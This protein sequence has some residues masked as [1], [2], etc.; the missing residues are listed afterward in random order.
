MRIATFNLENLDDDEGAAPPLAARVA[1]LRPILERL[2]VDVLCLQEVN[3]QKPDKHATR[4]L[5]AL[6]ALLAGTRYAGFERAFTTGPDGVGPQDVHNL[7]TLSRFPLRERRQIRHD[8]VAPPLYRAATARPALS[9]PQPVEWDR[10]IL[11]VTAELP[12]G[13]ALHVVNLHLRAPLAA[14]VA[15]QKESAARWRSLGGWAEGFLLAAM[16]RTGQAVEARLAVERLLDENPDAA[17]VVAGDCNAELAET[18]LRVLLGDA[19]EAGNPALAA[20][21]LAAAERH[22]PEERRFSLLHRGER[23]LIDHILVSRRLAEGLVRVDILTEHLAD[24][25]GAEPPAG[26]FHAPIVAEF[27][28]AP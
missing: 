3:G 19:E 16:R 22:V 12:G 14:P 4:R 26:S 25:S 9:E 8:F 20:R 6:D 23:L 18:P 27:R 24:D 10:P 21:I 7:V 11:A 1:A 2:E 5:D 17:I 28:L 13:A 15:G